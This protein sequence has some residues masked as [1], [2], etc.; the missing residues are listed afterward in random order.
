MKWYS[1][2]YCIGSVDFREVKPGLGSFLFVCLF[3]VGNMLVQY[4]SK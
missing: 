4:Q 2:W 1:K 3:C